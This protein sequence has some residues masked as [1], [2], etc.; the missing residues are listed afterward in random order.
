M[1]SRALEIT[2][3]GGLS[4][5]LILRKCY[6]DG[7]QL[8]SADRIMQLLAHDQQIY[9]I[10]VNFLGATAY[11]LFEKEEYMVFYR[12]M[13]FLHARCSLGHIMKD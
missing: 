3:L 1:I 5:K 10:L 2:F 6:P 8:A 9:G 13:L 12:D 7:T 4:Y 11:V